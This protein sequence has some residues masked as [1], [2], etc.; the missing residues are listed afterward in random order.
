MTASG[1][2]AENVQ[3]EVALVALNHRVKHVAG[4]SLDFGF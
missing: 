4:D 1:I 3:H 2:L